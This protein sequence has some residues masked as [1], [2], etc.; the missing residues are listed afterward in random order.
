MEPEKEYNPNPL[1]TLLKALKILTDKNDENFLAF[2][3]PL[4]ETLKNN[5]I[6]N[7][8]GGL[9]YKDV[10][11]FLKLNG[12]GPKEIKEEKLKTKSPSKSDI[13]I[14]YNNLMDEE[15][16]DLLSKVE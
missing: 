2:V 12:F 14:V 11:D 3:L 6:K 15:Q 8:N 7:N 1:I 5:Q 16:P 9:L 10:E 13:I 4:I